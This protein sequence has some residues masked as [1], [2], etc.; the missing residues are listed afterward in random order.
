MHKN[1]MPPFSEPQSTCSSFTQSLT[2]TRLSC[3]IQLTTPQYKGI[4]GKN[5]HI[6]SRPE[7]RCPSW[8]QKQHYQ[9]T[10]WP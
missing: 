6:N 7:S 1:M 2:V 5:L 8:H 9:P 10:E 3:P 4:K